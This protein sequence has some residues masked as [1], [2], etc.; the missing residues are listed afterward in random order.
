MPRERTQIDLG[1]P[2]LREREGV[3]LTGRSLSS[4]LAEVVERLGCVTAAVT[5]QFSG[6]EWSLIAWAG[7]DAIEAESI[8]SRE[9]PQDI[10]TLAWNSMVATVAETKGMAKLAERLHKMGPV[11]RVAVLE[12]IE[13]H[14]RACAIK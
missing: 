14:G 9:R 8:M 3:K 6:E 2:L 11:E 13:A 4:R 12:R 7:W 1:G 5:P 10:D